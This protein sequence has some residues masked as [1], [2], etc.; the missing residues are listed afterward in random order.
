MK[1]EILPDPDTVRRTLG[2]DP[3]WLDIAFQ[4]IRKT[5]GSFDRYLRDELRLS[6]SDLAALRGRLLEE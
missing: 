2:V 4:G 3:E 6:D 5:Y 1:L